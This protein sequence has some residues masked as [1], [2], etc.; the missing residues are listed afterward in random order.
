MRAVSALVS[1][2]IVPVP[3]PLPA[4][5]SE[6]KMKGNRLIHVLCFGMGSA[7]LGG[8]C[9]RKKLKTYLKGIVADA[10]FCIEFRDERLKK[11]TDIFFGF[12]EPSP[13]QTDGVAAIFARV[14]GL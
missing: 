12:F 14:D 2:P 1:N 4:I 8:L 13:I 7:L 10:W 5:A 9:Q 11:P 6:Q 3:P